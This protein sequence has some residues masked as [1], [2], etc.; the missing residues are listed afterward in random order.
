MVN[1]VVVAPATFVPFQL[2][3]ISDRRRPTA[4]T[5]IESGCAAHRHCLAHGPVRDDHRRHE[6]N[7]AL[8]K[9]FINIA[10]GSRRLADCH[11]P[12][13]EGSAEQRDIYQS[14]RCTPRPWLGQL[15]FPIRNGALY[16]L[17]PSELA[18]VPR[19]RHRN[20]GASSGHHTSQRADDSH[21]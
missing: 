2:P 20:K 5:D 12:I 16:R 15:K 19:E 8:M 7:G 18:A 9:K 1:C 14:G 3:P 6:R 13:A 21:C 17:N 4:D 10:A 11:A